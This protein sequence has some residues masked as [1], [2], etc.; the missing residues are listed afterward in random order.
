M[1]LLNHIGKLKEK[2]SQ[3]EKFIS[4]E[5]LRPIPNARVLSELKYKKLLIKEEIERLTNSF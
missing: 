5:Y 2:H 1:S 4:I 3:L